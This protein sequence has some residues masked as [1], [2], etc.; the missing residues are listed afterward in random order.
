MNDCFRD[1]V[2]AGQILASRLEG[3]AR[4]NDVIVLALARGG[5]P[6][7][8]EIAC[9]LRAPLDV[10][11]VRKLGVPDRDELAFGAVASGGVEIFDDLVIRGLNLSPAQVDVIVAR[12]RAELERRD[13]HYRGDRPF[14][15]LDDMIA[16]LVDD[17]IATGATMRAAIEATRRRSARSI[18]VAAPVAS[19]D[20]I[21]TLRHEA[22][23][24]VVEQIPDEFLSVG[25]FYGDFEPVSDV[26]VTSLLARAR[27]RVGLPRTGVDN[28]GGR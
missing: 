27:A 5:I 15:K 17:G 19:N 10:L 14:P 11:V 20:A 16:I 7:A 18:I 8:F 2:E 23:D 12:E 6:V 3:Y 22:D 21:E 24:I 28:G 4:R 9:R 13:R 26:E 25:Q 1:R